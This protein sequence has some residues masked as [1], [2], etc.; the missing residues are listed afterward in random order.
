MNGSERSGLASGNRKPDHERCCFLRPSCYNGFL[1]SASDRT[2]EQIHGY[3]QALLEDVRQE[4]G[5]NV[6][7][8]RWNGR[9]FQVI[10]PVV[11]DPSLQAAAMLSEH[12]PIEIAL[13]NAVQNGNNLIL[14]SAKQAYCILEP[15][16]LI[17]VTTLTQLDYCKRTYLNQRFSIRKTNRFL[18]KG[19]VIHAVFEDILKNHTNH[20]AL[21]Q[22][23]S[24]V[25]NDYALEFAFLDVDLTDFEQD[26]RSH[27]NRLYL[28]RKQKLHKIKQIF[29]ERYLIDNRMGLK[30]KIDAVVE[31]EDGSLQALELKTGKGWGIH[32]KR[33]HAF[34][35]Q[36]YSLMLQLKFPERRV[37]AP[38]IIYSGEDKKAEFLTRKVP[39]SYADTVNLM[40]MRNEL[41]AADLT[42][43]LDFQ[44]DEKR[45]LKC[46][47][48]SECEALAGLFHGAS[49]ESVLFNS[50][51]KAMMEEYS[52]IKRSQGR[53]FALNADE[54]LKQGRALRIMDVQQS[55]GAKH[56]VLFCENNSELREGERCLLSNESGP[57]GPHCVEC[58]LSYV[59][60]D[61]VKVILDIPADELWFKPAYL[62]IHSSETLFEVNFAGLAELFRNENLVW[63]SKFLLNRDSVQP[64]RSIDAQPAEGLGTGDFSFCA[65]DG[66]SKSQRQVVLHAMKD[67]GR[68]LLVQGPPGTGKT[69]TIA[70]MIHELHKAGKRVMV[71]CFTHRAVEEVCSKL[72]AAAP[73]LEFYYL[74]SVSN[75]DERLPHLERII[76]S[77]DTVHGRITALKELV[78][79]NPVYVATTQAWLSGRYD[80]LTK[81]ELFDVAIVDEAAQ[82]LLPQTIGAIRLAKRFILVGDHR[83]LPPVVQSPKAV[84]LKETLFERMIN[85]ADLVKTKIML[86]E[87]FRMPEPIA[88]LISREFYE[89]RLVSCPMCYISNVAVEDESDDVLSQPLKVLQGSPLVLLDVP[90]YICLQ[91]G[92]AKHNPQEVDAIIRVLRLSKPDFLCMSDDCHR[93]RLGIIA[94][95]R[96]QVAAI[97]KALQM[98]FQGCFSHSS[99]VKALVDTVD[100]FQG[101]E[102]DLILLSL[103]ISNGALPDLY[104]D[105]RRLNV[106]VSRARKQLI[107]VGDW[108]LAET[109]PVLSSFKKNAMKQKG[110]LYVDREMH[111]NVMF[112]AENRV[113]SD[114]TVHIC[115]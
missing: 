78:A 40:N 50:Y 37:L 62:D 22:K 110:C 64:C 93:P 80:F 60:H 106:A 46:S 113:L 9:L 1:M 59:G 32:A 31:Y 108:R 88:E 84:L 35:A 65:K 51:V 96:A 102:R 82:L 41:I 21:R 12:L 92:R 114:F 26:V 77:H 5:C 52:L 36:A 42:G 74:G 18:I 81:D 53:Y 39:M 67:D 15:N 79:S 69:Y 30:G 100:R 14:D 85:H 2:T 29:T 25:F 48:R 115:G 38:L 95:F 72:M 86:T 90:S 47:N 105:A 20:D 10:A 44:R 61:M 13:I 27:L 73:E 17:N 83:Q 58:V 70:R 87:Q 89:G 3:I 109:V 112:N 24:T 54:R 16:W 49:D 75:S 57:L 107:I 4:D 99:E 19:S 33:G 104:S 68:L 97:R 43:R 94:P 98:N 8:L 103:C 34:Q 7:F 66:L 11:F 76:S 28:Y 55:S 71:A 45:C 91:D 23:M 101:D 6:M 111:M 63:L 56:L